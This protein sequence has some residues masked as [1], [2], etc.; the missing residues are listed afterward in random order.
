MTSINSDKSI[1]T[2]VGSEGNRDELKRKIQ[3]QVITCSYFL[4]FES[5]DKKL[6]GVR[7]LYLM[8]KN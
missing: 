4:S 1:K 6:N 2:S 8:S 5:I 3:A 7:T